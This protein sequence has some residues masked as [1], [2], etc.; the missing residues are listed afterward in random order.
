[1]DAKRKWFIPLNIVVIPKKPKKVIWDAAAL[2][3]RVSLNSILLKRPELPTFLQAVS[4][5]QKAIPSVDGD[6]GSGIMEMFHQMLIR[7]QDRTAQW[8]MWQESPSDP[9]QVYVIDFES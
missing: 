5:R 1:M 2:V 9:I 8:F 7:V 6:D 4:C 3:Q